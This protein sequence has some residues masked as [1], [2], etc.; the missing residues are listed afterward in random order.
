MKEIGRNVTGIQGDVSSLDDLDRLFAQIKREKRKLDIVFANAGIAK[1]AS[2]RTI[3]EEHYN[4]IFNINVKGTR[5]HRSVALKF[6]Y[7]CAILPC[8]TQ[9]RGNEDQVFKRG[10]NRPRG[11]Q[12]PDLAFHISH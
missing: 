2:L 8:K 5:L 6:L 12:T 7:G 1:F 4:S 10:Y 11:T 9:Y 3:T